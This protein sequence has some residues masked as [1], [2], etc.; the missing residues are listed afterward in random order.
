MRYG[1][2]LAVWL[3]HL[4]RTETDEYPELRDDMTA[5]KSLVDGMSVIGFRSLMIR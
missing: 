5:V 4:I 3:F 2:I 1:P